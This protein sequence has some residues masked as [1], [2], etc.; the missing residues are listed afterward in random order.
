MYACMQAIRTTTAV[1]QAAIAQAAPAGLST[2]VADSLARQRCEQT[3]VLS[4]LTWALRQVGWQ[5]LLLQQQQQAV[6]ASRMTGNGS[7]GVQGG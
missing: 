5:Q 4:A 3:P 6:E 1:L 2:E 7:C